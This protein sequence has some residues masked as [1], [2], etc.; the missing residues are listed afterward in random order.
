MKDPVGV[1]AMLYL[2]NTASG[3]F[4]YAI[5]SHKLQSKYGQHLKNY[6]KE[7][8]YEINDS[9]EVCIGKKGDLILFDDR[10]FTDQISLLKKIEK[11]LF[12]YYRNK[13]FG[14]VVVTSHTINITDISILDKTQLRVLGLYA[15]EMVNREEYVSTRFKKIFFISLLF[16]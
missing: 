9:I 7:K 8:I 4:K 2:H 12:D 14:S 10:G 15:S 6:P 1:G 3:A 16:G 11:Y 5:G 13:T